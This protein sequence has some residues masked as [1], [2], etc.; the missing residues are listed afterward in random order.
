M[1]FR[2]NVQNKETRF[3]NFIFGPIVMRMYHYLDNPDA[4]LK[5]NYF[6]FDCIYMHVFNSVVHISIC[7]YIYK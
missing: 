4:A 1:Y 5:V 3:G 6:P 2:F 7:M